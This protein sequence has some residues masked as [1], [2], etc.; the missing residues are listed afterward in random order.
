MK[1]SEEERK[2][3]FI[4]IYHIM[5]FHSHV[6]AGIPKTQSQ[7][8]RM[9]SRFRYLIAGQEWSLDDIE[10][11]ILRSN[12]PFM[13]VT[14]PGGT[15]SSRRQFKEDDPRLRYSLPFDPRI[16]FAL[17]HGCVLVW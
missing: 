4:N 6:L 17:M 13:N 1:L 2:S 11:G 5:V 9:F 7:R 3:F 16:H 15:Q 10:H 14:P 8:H 12:K